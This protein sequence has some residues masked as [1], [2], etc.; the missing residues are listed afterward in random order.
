METTEESGRGRTKLKKAVILYNSRTGTTRKL[1]E[2]I[3]AFLEENNIVSEIR[4]INDQQG[5]PFGNADYVFLGCWTSGLL[6]IR[7]KP[8]KNWVRFAGSLPPLESCRTILFTTYKLRTGSMFRNMVKCLNLTGDTDEVTWLAS[9]NGI[10]P[11]AD[12]ELL[13]KVIN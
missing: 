5:L 13:A 8:E 7:Q 4:D 12:R 10:L 6:L 9:R 2:N 3:H 11:A 1:G